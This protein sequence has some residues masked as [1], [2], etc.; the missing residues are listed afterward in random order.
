MQVPWVLFVGREDPR[1]HRLWTVQRL[2]YVVQCVN[3]TKHL[4]DWQPGVNAFQQDRECSLAKEAFYLKPLRKG[5]Q[6]VDVVETFSYTRGYH[7]LMSVRTEC[8]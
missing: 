7:N 3:G 6:S 1:Q 8:T 4:R 5:F 2:S